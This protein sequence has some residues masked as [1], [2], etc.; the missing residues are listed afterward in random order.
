VLHTFVGGNDGANPN[1]GVVFDSAGNLY[2]TTYLGGGSG[3]GGKGCGTVFELFPSA[4][5]T[6]KEKVLHR[7]T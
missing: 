3:C 4:S 7:F 1:G 5:D 2:G 6:W